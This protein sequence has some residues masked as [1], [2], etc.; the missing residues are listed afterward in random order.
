VN[1]PIN[2]YK[3]KIHGFAPDL[4]NVNVKYV[5]YCDENPINFP[6]NVEKI[7]SGGHVKNLAELRNLR[8]LKCNAGQ[9]EV[10]YVPQQLERLYCCGYDKIIFADN[11]KIRKIKVK[12]CGVRL[13]Q[14]VNLPENVRVCVRKGYQV[15]MDCLQEK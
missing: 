1:L 8:I 13:T 15:W 6:L 4:T 7:K 5:K 12:N 14:F 9:E 11:A 2:L 10:L 3:L